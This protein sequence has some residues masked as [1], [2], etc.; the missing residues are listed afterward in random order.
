[1]DR[2]LCHLLLGI[3]LGGVA[4]QPKYPDW[5]NTPPPPKVEP[6]PVIEPVTLLA[7]G[8]LYVIQHNG[9]PCQVLC[10]P[11]GVVSVREFKGKVVVDGIFVDGKE[12]TRVYE[13][14]QVFLV[15]R[16]LPGAFELLKLPAGLVERRQLSDVVPQPMPPTPEP[17]P[18]PTPTPTPPEP[19]KPFIDIDGVSVLMLFESADLGKMTK[20]Q[21]AIPW[22]PR[23]YKYLDSVCA[24]HPMHNQKA[25]MVCDKDLD[26]NLDS[27]QFAAAQKRPRTSI[28]WA[29]ISSRNGNYEGPWPADDLA[30]IEL[31]KKTIGD[32]K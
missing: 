21:A 3:A 19:V 5:P 11:P 22:S 1:M 28:P 10:S 27:P 9:D 14:K 30:M 4:D 12:E 13:A 2:L 8:Q 15:K 31:V 20:E 23:L 18:T 26:L 6:I 25:Y 7:K 17:S 16:V 29:I 24:K 32:K